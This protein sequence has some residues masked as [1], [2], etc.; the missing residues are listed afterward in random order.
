MT[1]ADRATT[2]L[3]RLQAHIDPLPTA[4]QRCAAWSLAGHRV[5]AIELGACAPTDAVPP[6]V[7]AYT[8]L[9]EAVNALADAGVRAL[10]TTVGHLSAAQAHD[11]LPRIL[12]Q[13]LAEPGQ[14]DVVTDAE[15][16]AFLLIQDAAVHAYTAHTGHLPGSGSR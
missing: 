8:A 2:H 10:P 12:E 1:T 3:Q 16:D 9:L 7:W 14:H 5:A 4:A 11:L 15:L 13:V 6:A